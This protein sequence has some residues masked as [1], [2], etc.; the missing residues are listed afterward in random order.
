MGRSGRELSARSGEAGSAVARKRTD[1]GGVRGRAGDKSEDA[2]LLGVGAQGRGEREQAGDEEELSSDAR[3]SW[4]HRGR[5][6]RH[7]ASSSWQG[8]CRPGDSRSVGASCTSQAF[9]VEQL[10]ALLEILG[11][12]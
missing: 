8:R 9:D 6:Q 10:R 7:R 2:D 4:E 11:M 5:A 1:D 12:A 3:S